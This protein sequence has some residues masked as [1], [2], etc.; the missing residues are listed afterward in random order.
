[1]LTVVKNSTT[2]T[3]TVGVGIILSIN[4]LAHIVTKNLKFFS[5]L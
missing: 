2:N 4:C 1:M 3:V 5:F